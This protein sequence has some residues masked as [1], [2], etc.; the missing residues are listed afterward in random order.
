MRW[1]RR[2]RYVARRTRAGWIVSDRR[3]PLA[4]LHP[5]YHQTQQDAEDWARYLNDP[6]RWKS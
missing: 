4:D 3:N 2:R 6:E 5:V 1:F